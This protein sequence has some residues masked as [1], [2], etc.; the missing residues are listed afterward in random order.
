MVPIMLAAML[1]MTAACWVYSIAVVLVRVR[2][3]IL[4]RESEAPWLAEAPALQSN[5]AVE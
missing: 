3:I 5:Y 2:T 4:E 1:I